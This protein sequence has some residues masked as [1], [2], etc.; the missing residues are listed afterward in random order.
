ME[1]TD[2]NLTNGYTQPMKNEPKNRSNA[3]NMKKYEEYF[4]A[5]QKPVKIVQEDIR[6]S[7]IKNKKEEKSIKH[8]DSK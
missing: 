2:A 1:T 3:K 7:I 6:P 5:E 4:V 8:K